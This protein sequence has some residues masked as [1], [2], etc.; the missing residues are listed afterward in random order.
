MGADSAGSC[1]IVGRK[2]VLE[3][4]LFNLD[5]REVSAGACRR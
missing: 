4:E 1:T 5:G 2:S 3:E